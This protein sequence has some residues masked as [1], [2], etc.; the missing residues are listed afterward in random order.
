MTKKIVLVPSLLLLSCLVFV[1]CSS[2]TNNQ[3]DQNT[4]NTDAVAADVRQK[5]PNQVFDSH[6]VTFEYP[7]GWGSSK[8]SD[9]SFQVFKGDAPNV[10]GPKVEFTVYDMH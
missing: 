6:Y 8:T 10:S 7:Y 5:F 9:L 3:T 2:K 4:S 1:G